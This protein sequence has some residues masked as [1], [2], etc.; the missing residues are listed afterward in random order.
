MPKNKFQDVVLTII[1]ATVMVY[2][3]VV[4]NVALNTGGVT[5][6]TFLL[7][8]HELPIMVP[9]AFILEFFIVGKLARALAF[10]VM[11]PTDRPQFI[12]Y[13]ISI[14]ICCIMCPTMSLVATILFK[15][16]HTFG[17]WI[18]TWAMNFPMALLYQLFYCGPFVRLIFR[19]IFREKNTENELSAEAV[20]E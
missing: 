17:T 15:D 19:T 2:G 18:Q 9:I 16:T 6:Q 11:K 8:L 5:G 10:S 20:A 7:A 13:A 4:Y 1:M 3:M 14:C 12:T